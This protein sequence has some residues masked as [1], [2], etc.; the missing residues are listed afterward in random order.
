MSLAGRTAV[1]TGG[2]QGLGKAI[3]NRLAEARAS[4]LLADVNLALA[5]SAAAELSASHNARVVAA[6][7]DVTDTASIRAAVEL[8]ERELGG[9]D[10]WVNNAGVFPNIDLLEMDDEAWDRV[11]SVNM[12]G[13]FAGSREAARSMIDAGR[14]GVIVNIVSRAGFQGLA[15]GLAAYV[16]SKHGVRGVT[17]QMGIELAPHGIRVLGVAPTFCPTE[18]NMAALAE[19]RDR[20]LA[21]DLPSIRG[22]RLGRVGAPDDI[23]RAVL[24][25]T[26]DMSVFMTG[27]T[28]MVD[29][30]M[31]A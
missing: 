29:G 8:C 2:A 27:S 7:M 22:S 23:A 13:V 6:R 14:R 25:C 30:G 5:Q 1:V 31:S 26:S 10:I 12:R 20:D 18:G 21:D 15:P 16:A 28:L 24:F 17:A 4:V 19:K 11:M 3:G 9:V